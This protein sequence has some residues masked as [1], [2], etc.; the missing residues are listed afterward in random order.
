MFDLSA[1]LPYLVN[2]AGARMAQEFTR[3]LKPF[4]VSLQE[5]RVLA[6]LIAHGE[7]R[8]SQLAALT[9]IERTTLSR[10]IGRMVSSGL[11]RQVENRDD[12]REVIVVLSAR[13]RR[14]TQSILP[15]AH[16]YERKV[17]GNVPPEQEKALKQLLVRVY[18][19]LNS[20]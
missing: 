15:L 13:G 19:N 17:L 9:S 20:A 2:R 18:Q 10:I 14:K 6:A 11:V 5:W 3:A 7:Q 1:F 4:G 16:E 8:M 12:F